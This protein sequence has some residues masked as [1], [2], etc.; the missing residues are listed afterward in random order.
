MI[1]V[2]IE[3]TRG[4]RI[5]VEPTNSGKALL[6]IG[7]N[8]DVFI[9]PCRLRELIDHLEVVESQLQHKNKTQIEEIRLMR[10]VSKT[11]MTPDEIAR[12]IAQSLVGSL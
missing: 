4:K 7:D 5:K 8:A 3:L 9:E 11:V 12:C 10:H 2:Q 1:Q 6:T